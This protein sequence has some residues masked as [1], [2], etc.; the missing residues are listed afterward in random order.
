MRN[1]KKYGEKCVSMDS[2]HGLNPNGFELTTL[3]VLDDLNQGFPCTFMFSNRTDCEMLK[4]LLLTVRNELG[5]EVKTNVFMS[6]MAEEFFNAWKEIIGNPKLR[7]FCTWQ[8][9]RAWHKKLSKI[10]GNTEKQG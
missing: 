5:S 6:D 2:T 9:D 8:V 4:I 7:L 1:V 3:L 10:K